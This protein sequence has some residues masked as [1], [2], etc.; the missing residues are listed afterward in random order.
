MPVMPGLRSPAPLSISVVTR[1]VLADF[2]AFPRPLPPKLVFD[3]EV[4]AEPVAPWTVVGGV[5]AKFIRKRSQD[6][7]YKLGYAKRF[8]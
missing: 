2:A 4:E 3:A 8:Q 6:L 7:R 5:P 1:I